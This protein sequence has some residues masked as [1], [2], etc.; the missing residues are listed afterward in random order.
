VETLLK[1]QD[2][3]D[4]TVSSSTM[5][6]MGP[7]SFSEASGMVP[8][9]ATPQMFSNT[10]TAVP[11]IDGL[12]GSLNTEINESICWELIQMGL[13]EPLPAAEVVDDMYGFPFPLPLLSLVN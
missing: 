7:A 3:I 2:S 9:H 5:M 13:D 11:Q 10:S 1:S 6:G 8:P 12:M 4:P